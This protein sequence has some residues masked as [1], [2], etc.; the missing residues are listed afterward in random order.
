MKGDRSLDRRC[1]FNV[2]EAT[3]DGLLLSLAADDADEAQQR[4][5]GEASSSLP[6]RLALG[7]SSSLSSLDSPSSSGYSHAAAPLNSPVS[8]G[9]LRRRLCHIEQ[10]DLLGA[11]AAAASVARR[12][13]GL[14]AGEEEEGELVEAVGRLRMDIALRRPQQQD[15]DEEKEEEEERQPPLPAAPRLVTR[16][17]LRVSAAPSLPLPLSDDDGEQQPDSGAAPSSPYGPPCPPPAFSEFISTGAFSQAVRSRLQQ[18]PQPHPP[19]L[20]ACT[21]EPVLSPLSPLAPLPVSLSTPAPPASPSLPPAVS[22]SPPFVLLPL[23]LCALP[24][25]LSMGVEPR[26]LQYGGG[27]TAGSRAAGG[28]SARWRREA[29]LS[30]AAGEPAGAADGGGELIVPLLKELQ[31]SLR[32]PGRRK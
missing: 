10:P 6:R 24:R 31:L 26:R 11:A 23:P 27:G 21:P 3:D 20:S 13:S 19:Q 22:P 18:Q 9:E 25:S 12:R 29:E 14:Q 2:G 8:G 16:C 17:G 28:G 1:S 32:L 4:Q 15:E 5:P 30:L 7:S